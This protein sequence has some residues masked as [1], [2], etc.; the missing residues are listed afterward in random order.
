MRTKVLWWAALVPV[1]AQAQIRDTTITPMTEVEVRAE[2]PD[3]VVQ[4]RSATLTTS[5]GR[6]ELN[7]AACCNLSESFET[8]PAID[9]NFTNNFDATRV[10]GPIF[11]RM[12][13][14]GINLALTGADD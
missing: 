6:D 5:I 1:W 3:A 2:A 8:N 4:A 13:Y 14:L 9:P 7:K 11:G 12:L 10:W